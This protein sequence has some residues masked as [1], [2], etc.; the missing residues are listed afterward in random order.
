MVPSCNEIQ[1]LRN[2]IA[3]LANEVIS[4][5]NTMT[6]G[7]I[8]PNGRPGSTALGYVFQYQSTITVH[9]QL[10][11]NVIRTPY[12]S[13]T[14]QTTALFFTGDLTG[15]EP[16]SIITIIGEVRGPSQVISLRAGLNYNNYRIESTNMLLITTLQIQI[17]L[18]PLN[19]ISTPLSFAITSY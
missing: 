4:M 17:N 12:C 3:S 14:Q 9:S 11:P 16:T 7:S 18:I 10:F 8:A 6:P 13:P 19:G 15:F 1:D 2:Q 5:R